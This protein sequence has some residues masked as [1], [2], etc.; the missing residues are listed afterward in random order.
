[1]STTTS[2]PSSTATGTTY[3]A[4]AR[5]LWQ[6]LLVNRTAAMVALLVVAYVYAYNQVQ[7]FDSK[8]TIYFLLMDMAPILLMAL[9]MTLIIVTG[10]IDLSVAST[11]GLSAVVTGLLV[12]DHGY[13][14]PV[15]AV[16]AL[17]V[18]LACGLLNGFLVA[19][20]GLPSL[21]VTIGTLA[22]YRG[23]AV[24]LI[25]TKA[26]SGM[27]AHWK[28]LVNRHIGTTSYPLVV[29]PIAVLAVLFGLLLH[30]TPF[31]RGVYEVGLN[32]ETA[33]FSGVDVRRTKLVLY[34]L[35]GV[36]SAFAGVFYLLR[37]D[38]A[39]TDTGTGLELQVIAAVL[40]G[41]VSIFGGKGDLLGVLAG[42][43]LIGVLSSALRLQQT[44]SDVIEIVIGVLLVLSVIS[45]QLLDRLRSLR[46]RLR[47]TARSAPAPE[48]G[49]GSRKVIS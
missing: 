33:H 48:V 10:E 14:L 1:M 16:V 18:G 38:S 9:P 8:L 35:S 46:G 22:L 27:P 4:Y 2:S 42:V 26:I 11:L 31:G 29:I 37:F 25:G 41:G 6:R 12:H 28:D 49:D 34:A 44:G 23:V 19:Y 32:A 30:L 24:G 43:L 20:V 3:A 7:F 45:T 17:V 36:V 13:A 39:N 15:A 47:R 40:L 21:A 5:P